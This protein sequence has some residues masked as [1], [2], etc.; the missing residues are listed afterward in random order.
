MEP[1][2]L[3]G[4][5]AKR[6]AL[7][8]KHAGPLAL[9]ACIKA[10]LVLSWAWAWTWTWP[11]HLHI[12]CRAWAAG[13]QE[14]RDTQQYYARRGGVFERARTC[15]A[16][17]WWLILFFFCP[18]APPWVWLVLFLFLFLSLSCIAS[19]L[20]L[21]QKNFM[22]PAS[23]AGTRFFVASHWAAGQVR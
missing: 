19:R 9:G 7:E 14:M 6:S 12:C 13:L 15:H 4:E 16:R 21:C 10:C 3:K 8:H 5:C 17:W 23:L 18:R 22:L 20:V 1:T 11:F 2:R